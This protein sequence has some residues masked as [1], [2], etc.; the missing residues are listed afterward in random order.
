MKKQLIGG[1]LH[2]V[3]TGIGLDL[4]DW[5]MPNC[6]RVCGQ[7]MA[8][9]RPPQ[10]H[11]LFRAF[12][13]WADRWWQKRE[14]RCSAHGDRYAYYWHIRTEAKTTIFWWVTDHMQWMRV[15]YCIVSKSV[16]RPP[17]LHCTATA[18][19]V[20]HG[21][22][23]WLSTASVVYSAAVYAHIITGGHECMYRCMPATQVYGSVHMHAVRQYN[24]IITAAPLY[25]LAY[26]QTVI[27][28]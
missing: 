5:A 10:K 8:A 13:E 28:R 27:V 3:K 7:R 17:P 24:R 14:R 12:S 1:W 19:D 9:C 26:G 21:R 22:P 15:H 6:V 11:R 2:N 20:S 4:C 16:Y 18:G 25:M 23:R